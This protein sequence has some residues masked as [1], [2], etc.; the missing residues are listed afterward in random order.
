MAT[1]AFI[2]IGTI[3]TGDMDEPISQANTIVVQ[4][5]KIARVGN[6]DILEGFK[7]DKTIDVSGM[8]V[9]PGLIDSHVHPV[10]GDYTPRQKTQDYLDSAIHGGVT[11]FISAGEP[12][13]PG[14]PKDPAGTKALAILAHK[15][16]NNLRSSGLKV[17]GGA[18]ILEKGLVE[19]DFAEM[20]KEGVWLVGEV[21]LGSVKKPEDAV[22]MVNWAK[23]YGMKV[24]MHTGGTSIPGSSVVGADDIIAV[25]PT[26]SSH[27]NG[28]PTAI[29]PQEVDRLIN[30]TTMALEIVQCGNPK[31]ADYTVRQLAAKD[32][33][34]RVI[35]GN[36]SPSGS[37]I[38]PL[39]ILR[40]ICLIA[41][42]SDIP[43]EKV[44]A[45][46]TGNTARVFGLDTGLI[47]EGKEAD[48]IVIDTPI[49]SIGSNALEAIAAGDIP[50]VAL[51]MIDGIIKANKSRNTPPSA[52]DCIVG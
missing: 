21:G 30:E 20:A 38:I 4:D 5:G 15:S 24:A 51:V 23:K 19:A 43:A 25:Q 29:S 18:V 41:S 34:G 39:G 40:T 49:G 27:I 26:V 42:M 31:I 46:A 8:T 11:T 32:D 28:G 35:L 48:L 33:L 3:L 6:A 7:L 1:I 12:H 9:A 13:V 37:G 44:V 36:D 10:I 45:M 52:R 17:H 22:P 14:R 16:F 50:A 47:K 2:N